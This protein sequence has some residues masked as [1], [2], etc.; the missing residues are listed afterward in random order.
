MSCDNSAIRHLHGMGLIEEE[1][2]A[3]GP[4]GIDERRV[5][6]PHRGSGKYSV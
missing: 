3:H 6:R 4:R 1:P 5:S 2:P